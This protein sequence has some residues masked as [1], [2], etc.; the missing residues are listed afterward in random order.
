[1]KKLRSLILAALFTAMSFGLTGCLDSVDAFFFKP[2]YKVAGVDA[3]ET[4]KKDLSAFINDRAGTIKK[5]KNKAENAD[6][7][8]YQAGLLRADLA[9]VLKSKGYY[10]GTVNFK[11][12]RGDW[13]GT[14]AIDAGAQYKIASVTL[15]P[16]TYSKY[17][18][19]VARLQDQ[20]L[21]AEAVLK[22]EA[23]LLK[24]VQK[25]SCAFTL[26][27]T[28]EVLLDV[29]AKTASVAFTVKAGAKAVFGPVTFENNGKVS[30]GYLAKMVPWK[31]GECFRRD[32]IESLR[33]ALFETALFSRADLVIPDAPKAGGVVPVT[34]QLKERPPRS[35]SFGLSYYTDEGPGVSASW[36]HRNFLGGGETV[37]ATAK[38]SSLL[39]SLQGKMTSPYFLRHD[40]SLSLTTALTHEDSDAYVE[41]NLDGGAAIKRVFSKRLS[42]TTGVNL[43]FSNIEDK[44]LRTTDTFGLLSFPQTMTYDSRDNP[45]DARHGW[46]LDASAEPFIDMLGTSPAFWKTEGSARTYV[47]FGKKFTLAGR[48][49]IGSILGPATADVPATERF[50][51]GGGGSVRGFGYQEV[52]PMAAGKPSGGRSLAE[53]SAE[54]RLR[55]TETIGA[56]A[57][58]DAGSVSETV[59]PDFNNLSVGAGLGLRYYTSFGPLRLDVGVPLNNKEDTSSSYQLY[60]SI[61]QAF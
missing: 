22:A 16:A 58:L 47:P 33:A 1:M 50:Y 29:K 42:A 26:D 4:L 25:D 37:E 31:E 6:I 54:A 35:V 39:Q 14:Y 15:K 48:A 46:L 12:G 27:V 8:H 13:Q 61:G 56:V 49:K 3:N 40:Q 30:Q 57:F 18:R 28:H 23:S 24:A 17:F 52:G 21:D 45:L 10:D 51:A 2:E 19:R 55:V 53:A 59:A 20:P 60:I 7:A 36:K 44:S 34:L 38:V 43:S 32:K 11:Q 5:P 41:R 9:D